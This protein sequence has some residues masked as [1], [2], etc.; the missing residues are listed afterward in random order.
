MCVCVSKE[1]SA[2]VSGRGNPEGKGSKCAGL[3]ECLCWILWSHVRPSPQCNCHLQSSP[4]ILQL[5]C[6]LSRGLEGTE[7]S[8]TRLGWNRPWAAKC[9]QK[10]ERDLGSEA[11]PRGERRGGDAETEGEREWMFQEKRMY[12]GFYL[13]L[14]W[15]R[16]H[17][18]NY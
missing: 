13:F 10:A 5:P 8:S 4:I 15:T 3:V 1:R 9:R 2:L 18:E 7:G 14:F 11:A 16:L 6:G 17:G 12:L